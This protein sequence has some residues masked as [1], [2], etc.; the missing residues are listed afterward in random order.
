M[1]ALVSVEV[2]EVIE[3]APA[4]ER[5]FGAARSWNHGTRPAEPGVYV[6][7]VQGGV[8]Y[9]GSAASL[10]RRLADYDDWI[11]KYDPEDR[12]EV[13]V[14]HMLKTLG[15]TVG[16]LPTIDYADALVLESRLIEW[17]RAKVGIAPIVVGWEAKKESR[18]ERS[19]TWARNLWND[20]QA[21]LSVSQGDSPWP[22]SGQAA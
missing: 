12:W 19:Q 5:H 17:H 14:V 8:L 4:L 13:S 7:S 1:T 11:V 15:A 21:L 10:A 18:R 20:Q 22:D 6:W 9:I 16:W 2:L 3:L